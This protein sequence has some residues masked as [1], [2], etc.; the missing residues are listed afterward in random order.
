MEDSAQNILGDWLLNLVKGC[1][2][3]PDAVVIDAKEDDMG[4]FFSVKVHEDDRGKVIGKK[5]ANAQ[6]L[7]TL[8]RCAGGKYDVRAALKVDVPGS[9]FEPEA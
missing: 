8:L 5:G 6:A 9:Q 3:N 4:L 1:V 7:R 2:S